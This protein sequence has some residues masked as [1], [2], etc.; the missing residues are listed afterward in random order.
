M[1][2][3]ARTGR[4]IRTADTL[5]FAAFRSSLVFFSRAY[6]PL[7]HETHEWFAKDAWVC[8]TECSECEG[9]CEQQ[10]AQRPILTAP[11]ALHFRV[12]YSSQ[13]S[14]EPN[15]RYPS[16]PHGTKRLM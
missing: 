6:C 14:A 15:V 12:R 1:I 10:V 11:T 9:L 7:C 13:W 4:V 5:N 8:D 3:C 2:R 16:S